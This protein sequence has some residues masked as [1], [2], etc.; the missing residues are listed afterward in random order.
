MVSLRTMPKVL[1]KVKEAS[2]SRN[3]IL[4]VHLDLNCHVSQ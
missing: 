3:N 1:S 2:S 4:S